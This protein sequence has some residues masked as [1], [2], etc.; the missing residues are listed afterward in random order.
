[1]RHRLVS[2]IA[3]ALVA[4]GTLA[5][6]AD[7][8]TYSSANFTA[9]ISGSYETSGT[10]TNTRCYRV[11]DNDNVTYF[12]ATGQASERTTFKAKRGALLAVSRTRGDRRI[13]AGGPTIPVAT[14][15]TRTSTLAGSTEPQGCRPNSPSPSCG[16]RSRSYKI[17]VY[18][19]RRGY[20]FSY[21]LSNG[22]STSI[23]EDPFYPA[24]PLV[25]GDSWW[26][27]YYSRGN[28]TAKVSTA[29]LFNP[30]VKR[31]VVH[32]SLSRSPHSSESD[33]SAQATETLKWTLTLTRRR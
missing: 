26:G 18:G 13:V 16:T 19:V 21:N 8:R 15:V 7:A 33:Y 5:A 2:I 17:A 27:A 24:C 4:G 12:T 11:D 20:G 23:P 3:L 32:G 22:Y 14:T 6:H 30:R 29:K 9:R 1:M 28:G 31:I 10:V 25:E